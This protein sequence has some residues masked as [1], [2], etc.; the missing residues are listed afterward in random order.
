[1]G[2]GQSHG[3][4]KLS[5]CI[6]RQNYSRDNMNCNKSKSSNK[7][8]R[9]RKIFWTIW[10][11][12]RDLF[13]AECWAL[14]TTLPGLS[15]RLEG[16]LGASACR[17]W[18]VPQANKDPVSQGRYSIRYTVWLSMSFV[19]T[20]ETQVYISQYF[21]FLREK[22]GNRA[23]VF[24]F[25]QIFLF[26]SSGRTTAVSNR[27]QLSITSY[28]NNHRDWRTVWDGGRVCIEW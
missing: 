3:H 15:E 21:F 8:N 24:K 11:H 2:L 20:R 17:S 13:H 19:G 28:D 6:P 16:R 10:S 7:C 4:W 12:S 1:M 22:K 14:T 25:H 23:S 18:G 9:V 5:K 26:L 27:T